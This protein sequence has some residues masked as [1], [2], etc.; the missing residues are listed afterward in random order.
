[1][2]EGMNSSTLGEKLPPA[3]PTSRPEV[4]GTDQRWRERP[5]HTQFPAVRLQ[6]RSEMP[7]SLGQEP[8][9]HP[10]PAPT[11]TRAPRSPP[12]RPAGKPYPRG[13]PRRLG[14]GG[15]RQVLP[16]KSS[17]PTPHVL[18]KRNYGAKL[19]ALPSASLESSLSL[20]LQARAPAA[21]ARATFPTP[22]AV[23]RASP[24]IAAGFLPL[25]A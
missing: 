21:P 14:G 10:F 17:P 5:R 6:R 1:M 13:R 23:P 22:D 7:D 18:R 9:G 4:P 19:V 3:A 2:Q 12:P 24:A 11:W 20:R 15:G 8:R 16:G 25:L